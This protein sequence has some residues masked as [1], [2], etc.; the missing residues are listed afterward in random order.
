MGGSARTDDILS[1]A[2]SPWALTQKSCYMCHEDPHDW[3]YTSEKCPFEKL[4][5]CPKTLNNVGSTLMAVRREGMF[6][7]VQCSVLFS[8]FFTSAQT[9]AHKK[10][11]IMTDIKDLRPLPPRYRPLLSPPQFTVNHSTT[12]NSPL[13]TMVTFNPGCPSLL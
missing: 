2:T 9:F 13:W 10:L 12:R 11:I 8:F 5:S 3:G 7:N 1:T 4:L 6:S